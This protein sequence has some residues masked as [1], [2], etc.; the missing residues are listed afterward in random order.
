MFFSFS[1]S[2]LLVN[3]FSSFPVLFCFRLDVCKCNIERPQPKLVYEEENK[4]KIER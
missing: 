2:I 4:D 1:I 3:L